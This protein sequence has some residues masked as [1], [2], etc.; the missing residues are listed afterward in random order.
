[1]TRRGTWIGVLLVTLAAGRPVVVRAAEGAVLYRA[2]CARC[3]GLDARGDGPDAGD[4]VHRP[5]SLRE[6]FLARYS[7]DELVA[8]IRSGSPLP[9]TFDPAALGRALEKIDAVVAYV[10]RLPSIDWPRYREGREIF[11]SRCE[12]CHGPGGEGA[13]P[14]TA[15][16]RIPPDLGSEAVRER[17]VGDRLRTAVRH[18]LPGMPGLTHPPDDAETAA[19]VAYVGTLSHGQRLYVAYCASC[20]GQDGHPPPGV[21]GEDRPKVAFDAEYFER[22][23]P[24]ELENACTH[25]VLSKT[26]RMPHFGAELSEA[27]TRKIVE[28]LRALP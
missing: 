11:L 26:P 5:R 28:Y 12:G 24:R 10:R 16:E 21:T 3:H 13:P 4:F 8:R 7:T 6:G 20:H 25:M 23:R 22:L 1:M 2:Y 15:L 18:E 19:L 17:L 9:L 14:G 27:E